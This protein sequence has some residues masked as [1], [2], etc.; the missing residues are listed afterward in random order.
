[1]AQPVVAGWEALD[2]RAARTGIYAGAPKPFDSPGKSLQVVT[3]YSLALAASLYGRSI[4]V[5]GSIRRG[6]PEFVFS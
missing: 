4:T 5:H 1:V 6:P 2:S 3:D